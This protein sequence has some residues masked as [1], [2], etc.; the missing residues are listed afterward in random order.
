M[1]LLTSPVSWTNE[2]GQY[3]SKGNPERCR[4]NGGH[5]T[6]S[7]VPAHFLNQ[8][9]SEPADSTGWK[10]RP[11]EM[12]SYAMPTGE[13]KNYSF[14]PAEAA[15]G[16]GNWQ[17]RQMGPPMLRGRSDC[18]DRFGYDGYDSAGVYEVTPAHPPE[19]T[20]G[21]AQ[22]GP[23]YPHTFSNS[24]SGH[25]QPA[26]NTAHR[27]LADGLSA[28]QGPTGYANPE[29]TLRR[30]Q[31]SIGLGT[32]DVNSGG[33]RSISYQ[34]YSKPLAT[35]QTATGGTDLGPQNVYAHFTNQP[36][37]MY[38]ETMT[39]REGDEAQQSESDPVLGPTGNKPGGSNVIVP[40]LE[41]GVQEPAL[42]PSHSQNSAHG[43]TQAFQGAGLGSPT[44]I[45][46]HQ[47]GYM[48]GPSSN[49]SGF[50]G[51]S[52]QLRANV[53][54]LG[55]T[56]EYREDQKTAQ[57]TFENN[58]RMMMFDINNRDLKDRFDVFLPGIGQRLGRRHKPAD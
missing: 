36:T 10:R 35:F 22:P 48:K 11:Q 4:R 29:P 38:S 19:T 16:T 39:D 26:F 40:R 55:A 56:G 7:D 31:S 32:S 51:L 43:D 41:Q 42:D 46:P 50:E 58:S 14:A 8:D 21:Y 52:A 9:S 53:S 37:A 49:D 45:G 34:Q 13:F 47:Y 24:S 44:S 27:Y 17:L 12:Q 5:A 6:Q 15:S 57:T 28:Q 20:Q 3:S 1:R 18:Q 33:T 25:I 54:V 23:G 30:T 2:P